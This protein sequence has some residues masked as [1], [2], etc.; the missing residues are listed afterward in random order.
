MC[1]VGEERVLGG[2]PAL[3]QASSAG[4]VSVGCIAC[5]S[6]NPAVGSALYNRIVSR[7]AESSGSDRGHGCEAVLGWVDHDEGNTIASD[8]Q[9]WYLVRRRVVHGLR[10]GRAGRPSWCDGPY[11]SAAFGCCPAA[12]GR[13][14]SVGAILGQ[15]I[16]R[17][18][19]TA[20]SS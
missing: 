13:H 11:V 4:A 7:F 19:G 12:G 18:V 1:G 3:R 2:V 10:T 9:W 5:L 15:P 20:P 8:A 16:M 6:C 14:S 17:A